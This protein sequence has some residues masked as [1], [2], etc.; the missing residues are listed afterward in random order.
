MG[1]IEDLN[2]GKYTEAISYLEKFKSED[3]ILG[4]LA[5]GAIGD[6]YA[7]KNQPKQA[8]EFYIKAS[9]SNKNEFT[10]PRFLLKAGQTALALGNKADALK[11]FTEIKEKY[12]AT[13]EASSIDAMI[14]LA[15]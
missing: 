1:L 10:T 2:T 6:A 7:Q 5:T 9:E 13:P 4:T 8:L 3:M 11:Y 14:G 15:Q 12:E